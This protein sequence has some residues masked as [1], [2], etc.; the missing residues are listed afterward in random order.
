MINVIEDNTGLLTVRE[1]VERDLEYILSQKGKLGGVAKTRGYYVE[2]LPRSLNYLVAKSMS[3]FVNECNL[4]SG[5]NGIKKTKV[6]FAKRDTFKNNTLKEEDILPSL[7][8]HIEFSCVLESCNETTHTRQ[9][10]NCVAISGSEN[11]NTALDCVTEVQN[12][13][14]IKWSLGNRRTN[15]TNNKYAL[16]VDDDTVIYNKYKTKEKAKLDSLN[17]ETQQYIDGHVF[18]DGPVT[19]TLKCEAENL[20]LK[21]S[22]CVGKTIGECDMHF[23]TCWRDEQ[24]RRNAGRARDEFFKGYSKELVSKICRS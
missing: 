2:Q 6:D 24:Q 20:S 9:G 12:E 11:T 3:D 23:Y 14:F 7:Q 15:D 8:E 10:D 13:A 1:V 21:S 16:A 5:K 19:H 18:E 17:G 22:N 4:L